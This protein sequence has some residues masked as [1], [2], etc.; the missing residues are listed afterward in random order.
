MATA[1]TS[2]APTATW[3]TAEDLLEALGGIA[4][5]RVRLRPF[6][7]TATEV[8]LVSFNQRKVAICEL[9]DGVLVEKTMGK[10][11]SLLAAAII[12][13]LRGFVSPRH[14]GIITAPDGMMRLSPTIFRAPDVAFIAW[15]RVPEGQ[16]SEESLAEVVPDLA[17]EV[18][19]PSN[20]KAEMARK[21]R[22]YFAAGVR[23][24]WEVDPR[25]RT[26]NVY[27]APDESTLLDITMTLDGGDVLPGF[28]LPLLDLF[29]E[30]EPRRA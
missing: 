20:T 1:T 27:H 19:S 3:E 4:P 5:G 17:I 16:L 7:G 15:R 6:P 22:E 11:E 18:L 9:V 28:F 14:L 24:V 23:L 29:G 13:I 21:R 2:K 10:L 8:D 26:V 30:L 12:A 25:S